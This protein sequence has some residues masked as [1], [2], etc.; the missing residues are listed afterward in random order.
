MMF[1]ALKD[2]GDKVRAMKKLQQDGILD[3]DLL[4][5]AMG[6][7]DED[8]PV[9]ELLPIYM[10]ESLG[11]LE[12]LLELADVEY[13]SARKFDIGP[14]KELFSNMPVHEALSELGSAYSEEREKL[15]TQIGREMGLD[16]EEVSE[17]LG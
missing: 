4:E 7:E 17:A 11:Q 9:T 12:Q 14:I 2:S 5:K 13:D 16:Q 10:N 15:L 8:T 6:E 1:D 3:L